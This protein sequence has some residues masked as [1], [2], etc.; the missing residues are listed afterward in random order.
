MKQY[1]ALYIDGQL[2]N[3][4]TS[5]ITLEWKSVMLSNIS[6]LKVCHSYTIKLPMTANN[7]RVFE[8][9]EEAPRDAYV[10]TNGEQTPIGRRMSARYYCNGVDVLGNANAYLLGTDKEYYRV[11]LTWGTLS[12]LQTVIEDDRTLPEIFTE[13]GYPTS[14]YYQQWKTSR[15]SSV[16]GDNVLCLRYKTGV[17][18]DAFYGY[19]YY[20]P[21]FKVT[22]LMQKIFNKYGIKYDLKRPDGTIDSLLDSLYCPMTS[23]N[24][25][26]IYQQQARFRWTF[27]SSA[28]EFG[29]DYTQ[30]ESFTHPYST[31][32]MWFQRVKDPHNIRLF[33][34]YYQNMAYKVKAHVRVFFAVSRINKTEA[35]ISSDVKLAIVNG[36]GKDDASKLLSLTPTYIS[37]EW[38]DRANG[39]QAYY[40]VRYEYDEWQEADGNDTPGNDD[41]E[42]WHLG[43]YKWEDVIEVRQGRRVW[44]DGYDRAKFGDESDD[45][46]PMNL[47]SNKTGRGIGSYS[48]YCEFIPVVTELQPY[49]EGTDW[50]EI[51]NNTPSYI[52]LEPNFPDMK[53]ID[54]LKGIFYIVGAYP[55]IVDETL[56]LIL[57]QDLVDNVKKAMD[58]SDYIIGD[59]TLPDNIKFVLDDW[60]Q[61]NWLR[62]KDDDD[63]NPKFSWHFDIDDPYLKEEDDVFTLPFKGCDTKDKMAVVP[64]YETGKVVNYIKFKNNVLW[65]KDAS[66]AREIAGYVFKEQKPTIGVRKSSYNLDASL[67]GSVDGALD[68]LSFEELSF[69]TDNGLMATRYKV[70]AELL[71]HPYMIT[72][73]FDI[74]EI[75]LGSLDMSV[76]VYLR[77]YA[78]YFGIT[79]IKRKSDG[80]CT[81]ELLRIPNSLITG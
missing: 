13:S 71:R 78:S 8:M 4:G 40:E 6:K 32:V 45:G 41:W 59:D 80:K 73:A 10:F 61:R 21:S 33:A 65:W 16:L 48:N 2:V 51:I 37:S 23:M 60:N 63:D 62:W 14:L 72:A 28:N 67:R 54:F 53:P 57:Y 38:V 49:Q 27:E 50:Y 31:R 20:L 18:G 43:E 12:A 81:V 5:D 70:F 9:A 29:D 52:Y 7:R 68:Y 34:G 75:T 44:I 11:V 24:D 55:V 56:K 1:E 39:N 35:E 46:N 17:I 26:E 15:I 74:D 22:W 3:I 30:L 66:Y 77:Q 42:G 76:P 47:V 64:I 19:L 58:W 36:N 25:S 69:Q 79:S